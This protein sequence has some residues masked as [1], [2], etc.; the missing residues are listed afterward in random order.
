MP[1]FS[2]ESM[3]GAIEGLGPVAIRTTAVLIRIMA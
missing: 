3:Q 2:F 1:L